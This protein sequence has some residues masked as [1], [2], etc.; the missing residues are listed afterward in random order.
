M[1][2]KKISLNE[3]HVWQLKLPQKEKLVRQYYNLLSEDEKIRAGKYAFDEDRNNFITSRWVLRTL[4]GKYLN[5]NPESIKFSYTHYGK[6]FLDNQKYPLGLNF[7][8]SDTKGLVIYA[9]TLKNEIGVDVEAIREIKDMEEVAAR[10]FSIPEAEKLKLVPFGERDEAFLSC[11]TLKEAYIKAIGEGL[12]CPLD[13]FDMS[14]SK[15]KKPALLSAK[16]DESEKGRWQ[17]YRIESPEG[18]IASLAIEGK[19]HRLIY[20][21]FENEIPASFEI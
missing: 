15:D 18:Y 5:I 12:S 7:N 19:N 16:W 17:M 21:D 20:K 2:G 3:I 4:I 1:F 14:F 9:F 13:Q 8:L 6:P 10:F 11:W